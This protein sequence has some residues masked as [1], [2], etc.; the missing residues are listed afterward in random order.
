MGT[1]VLEVDLTSPHFRQLRKNAMLHDLECPVL[2]TAWRDAAFS[3][4]A[5]KALLPPP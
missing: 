3:A 2:T 5:L 1:N 4:A